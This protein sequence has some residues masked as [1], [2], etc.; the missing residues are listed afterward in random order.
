[1]GE[2]EKYVNIVMM[3]EVL[4]LDLVV[5]KLS[6]DPRPPVVSPPPPVI[7]IHPLV[8]SRQN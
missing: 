4:G 7:G 2:L 5:R 3:N 8:G 6:T 1:M